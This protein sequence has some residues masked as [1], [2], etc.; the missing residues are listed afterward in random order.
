MEFELDLDVDISLELDNNI[1]EL[2]SLKEMK[3][4][5]DGNNIILTFQVNPMN[6]MILQD[7]TNIEMDLVNNEN[8]YKS[9]VSGWV[10]SSI[11][12]FEF[13]YVS[14]L[15]LLNPK[16]KREKVSFE[17]NRFELMDLE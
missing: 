15:V 7:N 12:S 3:I 14:L 6:Y 9:V 8:K 10:C 1:I 16:Y 5:K 11:E 17:T 4:D 13:Y 2:I